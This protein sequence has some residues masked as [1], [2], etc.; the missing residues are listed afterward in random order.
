M[1]PPHASKD[2]V[3]DL[4]ELIRSVHFSQSSTVERHNAVTV[5]DGVEPADGTSR[6]DEQR[7]GC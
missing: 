3:R 2:A 1:L 7:G 5:D 6:G 4:H